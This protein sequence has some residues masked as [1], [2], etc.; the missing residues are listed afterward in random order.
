MKILNWLGIFSAFVLVAA[1]S[2]V[3]PPEYPVEPA[4]EFLSLSK[5][6]ML[7]GSSVD[8]A[9][10]TF[11]FTDGDGDIGSKDSLDL[12]LTD[13]RDGTV[14]RNRIP[15][16]PELGA[17]NGIKGEIRLKINSTCCIFPDP[18][19]N[20]CTDVL[21]SYPYDQVRYS[22]YIKDRKGN[23]SNVLELVPIYVRCF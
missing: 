6:T 12:F 9:F 13:K 2:C 5:D 4:I 10:V 18:F 22:L 3:T 1:I 15:F 11:G 19:L 8:S 23:Q 16:V 14:L 20:G 17:S 7:R 21:P